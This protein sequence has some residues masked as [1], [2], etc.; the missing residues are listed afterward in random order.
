MPDRHRW[1][2]DAL[3]EQLDETDLTRAE[4]TAR[5]QELR[6]EARDSVVD[7]YRDAAVSLA[8]RY[9]QTESRPEGL[10]Y[11]ELRAARRERAQA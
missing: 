4:L 9:E 7:G 2:I 6:A 1:V 8:D 5:A 10:A 3:D 11:D